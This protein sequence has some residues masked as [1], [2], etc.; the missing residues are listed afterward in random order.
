MALFMLRRVLS[1]VYV[2]GVDK[3]LLYVIFHAL[4]LFPRGVDR[5]Q[6]VYPSATIITTY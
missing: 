5:D 4:R 6:F 2:D 3:F 1:F